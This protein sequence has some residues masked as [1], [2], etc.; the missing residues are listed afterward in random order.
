MKVAGDSHQ[1]CSSFAVATTKFLF[2]MCDCMVDSDVGIGDFLFMLGILHMC[3]QV[4]MQLHKSLSMNW[5][6]FIHRE[7]PVEEE[8]YLWAFEVWWP[9][10]FL[11]AL[12]SPLLPPGAHL[13]LGRQ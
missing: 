2:G 1:C 10:P 8:I 13:Q 3:R 7:V 9:V 6:T 12:M 11:A 5:D 4:Y